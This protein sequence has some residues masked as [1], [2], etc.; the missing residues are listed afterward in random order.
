MNYDKSLSLVMFTSQTQVLPG[1]EASMLTKPCGLE[2]PPGDLEGGI[3]SRAFAIVR[4][5]FDCCQ[6][7]FI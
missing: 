1:V 2:T 7:E 4:I 3:P 6:A 5:I